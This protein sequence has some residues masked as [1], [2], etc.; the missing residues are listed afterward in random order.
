MLQIILSALIVYIAHAEE[1]DSLKLDMKPRFR[2]NFPFGLD[3]EGINDINPS[4]LEQN[5]DD[6]MDSILKTAT[7]YKY[8]FYG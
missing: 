5:L 2:L 4:Y 6:N 1:N 3:Y 8:M 7:N